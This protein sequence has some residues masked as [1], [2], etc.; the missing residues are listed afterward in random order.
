MLL[1]QIIRAS[2]TCFQC[3][4]ILQL[5]YGT[6]YQEQLKITVEEGKLVFAF[7]SKPNGCHTENKG[8]E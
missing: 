5:S 6:C 3:F 2:E 8:G 7:S 1:V 4:I